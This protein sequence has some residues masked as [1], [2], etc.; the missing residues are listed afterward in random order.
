MS[1]TQKFQ[2]PEITLIEKVN[3]WNLD[4]VL[5]SPD[6]DIDLKKKL[7]KYKDLLSDG[8]AQVH[9]NYSQN[10]E[11]KGRL[12]AKDSLSLQGIKSSVRHFI[13]GDIYDD[14]DIANCYPTLIEQYCLKNNIQYNEC[15][16]KFRELKSESSRFNSIY[17][18]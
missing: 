6:I 17:P 15:Q 16:S 3:V 9:Y 2:K 12:F 4:R 14:I 8:K 10:L 1:K 18:I 13:A 5:S 7:I 11:D